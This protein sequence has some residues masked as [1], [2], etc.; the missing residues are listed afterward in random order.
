MLEHVSQRAQGQ[1]YPT[2]S[3][4]ETKK[5]NISKISKPNRK[6]GFPCART[7]LPGDAR[8]T[9]EIE[10]ICGAYTPLGPSHR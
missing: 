9:G 5:Q 10:T 4:I 7:I 8:K 2:W 3:N 1:R 6:G